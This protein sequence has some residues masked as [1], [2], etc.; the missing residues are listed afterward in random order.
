MSK[1]F[2]DQIWENKLKDEIKKDYMK[3]LSD[4]LIKERLTKKIFPIRSEV[5]NAFNLTPF[6]NS[7]LTFGMLSFELSTKFLCNHTS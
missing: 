2:L 6:P 7:P 1:I 3:S 4:F 5:F